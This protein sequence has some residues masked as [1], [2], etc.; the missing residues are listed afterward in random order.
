MYGKL[1]FN[2]RLTHPPTYT[3][4]PAQHLEYLLCKMLRKY[5]LHFPFGLTFIPSKTLSLIKKIKKKE[6]IEVFTPGCLLSYV[7]ICIISMWVSV[8]G[9]ISHTHFFWYK[10]KKI[11]SVAHNFG[12]LACIFLF[13]ILNV[14]ECTCQ[15]AGMC[16]WANFGFQVNLMTTPCSLTMMNL[17]YFNHDEF[18]KL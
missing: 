11:F 7:F 14:Q 8:D 12:K 5:C 16:N 9:N 15:Y 4:S 1:I 3:C 13:D 6:N 18:A 10:K 2:W 17:Q